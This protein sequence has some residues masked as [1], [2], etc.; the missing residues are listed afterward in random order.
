MNI[1]VMSYDANNNYILNIWRIQIKHK[2]ASH[3]NSQ[4][5]NI[6]FS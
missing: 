3:L 5:L 6:D 4:L 2:S 1:V